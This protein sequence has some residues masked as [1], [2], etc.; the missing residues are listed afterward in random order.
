MCADSLFNAFTRS[1]EVRSE[2]DMSMAE[3][4]DL[5]LAEADMAGIG[6]APCRTMAAE[7]I[8]DLQSRARHARRALG[9]R[10]VCLGAQRREVIQR[11]YDLADGIGGDAGIER[12]GL[13]FGV[14]K[15]S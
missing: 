14:P 3:Y 11:A 4:L 2:T 10:L 13:E 6:S 8:R 5:Q 12:R 9:R 1:F 15:Q 7:D